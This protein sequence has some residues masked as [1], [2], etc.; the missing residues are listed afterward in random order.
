M[1][2]QNLPKI[3][4]NQNKPSSIVDPVKNQ[5]SVF[6]LSQSILT[7]VNTDL[8][9]PLMWEEIIP[10][11]TF[12]IETKFAGRMATPIYP[13][14]DNMYVQYDWWFVP[15][16][17]VWEHFVNFWGER[18]INVDQNV[19]TD[20]LV[21]I[22]DDE[23][24]E[25]TAAGANIRTGGFG[26]NGL[27]SYLLAGGDVGVPMATAKGNFVT[28][29][30]ARS[31]MCIGYHWY[32]DQR[33]G[34]LFINDAGAVERVGFYP[35]IT[36][37]G[38]DDAS[39]FQLFKKGKKKNYF[40]SLAP[41]IMN[42]NDGDTYLKDVLGAFV[43]LQQLYSPSDIT[44]DVE[45]NGDFVVRGET[46]NTTGV[47]RGNGAPI[48]TG[49][50]AANSGWS[51]GEDLRYESGLA[52]DI[53][54]L[55]VSINNIRLFEKI[56][57]YYERASRSGTRYVEQ[58]WVKYGVTIEDS[59]LQL[60]EWLGGWTEQ[61]DITAVAQTSESGTTPL[62]ELAAFGTLVTSAPSITKSFPEH[63]FIMCLVSVFPEQTFQRGID[64]KL[65][66]R[67]PYDYHDHLWENLTEQ[68]VKKNELRVADDTTDVETLGYQKRFAEMKEGRRKISGLMR[69]RHPLSLDAWHLAQDIPD[70]TDMDATFRTYD[71]DMNRVQAVA[72]QPALI[73]YGEARITAAR[74]LQ[75]SPIP[76]LGGF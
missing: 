37:D 8:V 76:L 67:T 17:I 48:M 7:T 57:Q 31:Y 71:T 2:G 73:I 52:L 36:D 38:P 26:Y 6:D 59:R 10:S 19:Q 62:G 9:Y 55:G 43:P 1:L 64:R 49:I 24:S 23:S 28:S 12:K 46:S 45:A 54:N 21:P 42:G 35:L 70:N 63:G 5:R 51:S 33:Y 61:L 4:L 29:L 34:T 15:H 16:R 32:I 39:Q 60:P 13:I 74:P 3:A 53:E 47:L 66:R 18:S 58:T 40:T 25:Y 68:I 72:D 75:V 14:M 20:Y 44:V 41:D 65:Q 30:L 22:I 11:D 69:S 50:N 27:F 56:Q